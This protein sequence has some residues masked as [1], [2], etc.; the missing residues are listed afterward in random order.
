MAVSLLLRL[1]VEE[2]R[3]GR[4]G[5]EGGQAR[6][7]RSPARRSER[8]SGRWSAIGKGRRLALDWRSR[9]SDGQ[10]ALCSLYDG[11]VVSA[12]LDCRVCR[13]YAIGA[14]SSSSRVASNT[15]STKKGSRTS[16]K[17]VEMWGTVRLALSS[18]RKGGP[19]PM[20]SAPPPDM[21]TPCPFSTA[22]QDRRARPPAWSANQQ[23]AQDGRAREVHRR[24]HH[25]GSQGDRVRLVRSPHVSAPGRLSSA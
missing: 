17:L 3:A 19:L 11:T 7:P 13:I 23:D 10:R 16:A 24:A 5:E 2:G 8:A 6:P 20:R 22:S 15:L 21:L 18:A 12:L 1:G 25:H 4:P 14:R 9:R